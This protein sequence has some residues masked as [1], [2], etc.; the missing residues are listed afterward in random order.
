MQR[1]VFV[2]ALVACALFS[3]ATSSFAN[4]CYDNSPIIRIT[5]NSG[6]YDSYPEINNK[7]QIV[8]RGAGYTSEMYLYDGGVITRITNDG[9]VKFEPRINNSGQVVWYG[10]DGN[11]YEIYLYDGS[12][13]IQ[14][15]NNTTYDY[16]PRIGD[17]GHVAWMGHDG[18]DYEIYLYDGSRVTQ[19][20]DNASA[21]MYP[22]VNASGQVTWYGTVSGYDRVFLYDGASV[23]Q[24]DT[25]RSPVINDHGY[26][27]WYNHG[28]GEIMLYDGT[29][30][31]QITDSTIYDGWY[32]SQINNNGHIV[33]ERFINGS[34]YE[35]FYYDGQRVTQ[36]TNDGYVDNGRRFPR[37]NNNNY[38]VWSGNDGVWTMKGLREILLFDGSTT[39]QLTENS[40]Y[41]GNI[42][43]NDNGYIVWHQELGYASPW[44]EI[45]LIKPS[46]QEIKHDGI[47]Q[48]CNGF[49][50][51]ID[52]TKAN[53]TVKDLAGKRVTVPVLAVWLTLPSKGIFPAQGLIMSLFQNP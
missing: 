24:L 40:F 4:S 15:T 28:S 29:A 42:R 31:R 18:T 32:P 36:L 33:W 20:T 45:F 11:D 3:G 17:G 6:V 12:Q 53:Y 7:G 14:L 44:T 34:N 21:D 46:A 1:T 26:V 48:D 16:S 38:I 30:V 25:G 52:I 43:I 35:I 8:W 23:R 5:N 19:I 50:L 41:E 47:D 49:D 13:V 51:T 37:I 27:A 39:I 10:N 9:L 2:F 22:Q